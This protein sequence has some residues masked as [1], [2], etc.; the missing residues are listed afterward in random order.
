MGNKRLIF[1]SSFKQILLY[2][3]YSFHPQIPSINL[4]FICNAQQTNA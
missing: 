3:K 1:L 4:G 2:I